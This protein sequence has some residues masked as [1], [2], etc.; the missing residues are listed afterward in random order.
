M[1][2]RMRF[3][4]VTATFVA[5]LSAAAFAPTAQAVPVGDQAFKCQLGLWKA[6]KAANFVD[7]F[8]GKCTIDY[9]KRA[10]FLVGEKGKDTSALNKSGELCQ[11]FVGGKAL[12]IITTSPVDVSSCSPS[13]FAALGFPSNWSGADVKDLVTMNSLK[14]GLLQATAA[15]PDI[16]QI[17]S[18]VGTGPDSLVDV[19]SQC[20]ACE[21]LRNSFGGLNNGAGPCQAYSCGLTGGS[22]IALATA[23][24]SVPVPT[25]GTLPL[26]LCQFG[27]VSGGDYL[28]FNGP[29]R[30]IKASLPGLADVCVTSTSTRGFIAGIGGSTRQVANWETCQ[31]HIVG[32]GA[33][34][35]GDPCNN[36]ADCPTAETCTGNTA[37]DD[38]GPGGTGLN[39][40][41]FTADECAASALEGACSTTT[42]EQCVDDADCPSGQCSV[43]GTQ[44]CELDADCPTAETCG[45]I[46]QTCTETIVTGGA[47]FR[48]INSANAAEGEA[49]I[50][51]T[52]M[53]GIV[54]GSQTGTDGVACT[55]DDTADPSAP[56]PVVLTTA[57]AEGII[58]NRNQ[59]PFE[60]GGPATAAWP[61]GPIVAT[62]SAFT[63]SGAGSIE[64]GDL[65]GT[66][67]S[68][69]PTLSLDMRALLVGYQDGIISASLSCSAP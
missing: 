69:F 8:V 14:D 10:L 66:V 3:G 20:S 15:S 38:C 41:P 24:I 33:C 65:D 39:G 67:V 2:K 43:T 62:G 57:N 23:A 63:V 30:T 45:A 4:I 61:T 36:D 22:S 27:T 9:H 32:D 64:T 34:D 48:S 52:L 53:N 21:T 51:A 26:T 55:P 16:W 31:D 11:I 1:M 44:G 56:V 54:T 68:A 46:A 19:A 18:D 17:M 42:D 35:G 37:A 12:P 7:K 13:D 29:A 59:G 6:F 25:G 49:S 40:T 28:V 47:C 58:F 5:M 50:A 60:L